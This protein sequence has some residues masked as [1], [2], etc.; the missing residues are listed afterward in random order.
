[1]SQLRL[2]PLTGRWVTVVSER[3]ERPTDFAPRD[4]RIET[5]DRPCPF[6]PGHEE[7]TPPALETYGRDGR[8]QIRVVPNLFPA[9]DGDEPMAVSHLGPVFTQ[10][11][12]S[13]IH[14]ILVLSPEHGESW[15]DLEDRDVGLLMAALRD[16][17]EDH[18]R[19]P[20]IRYT[21]AV[22]NYGREAGA[23]LSHP[24]GQ[25]LGMPFVPGE[26]LEEE[27]GFARFEGSCLICTTIE[28]ELSDN[29][30]VVAEDERVVAVCPFWSG[31]P[32]EILI[33]PKSHVSHLQA[34]SPADLVAVGR[35]IRGVLN[36][37]R[38]H[39]GDVAY[40]LVFHT[41]PHRHDGL[42]HWHVHIWPKLSTLAGFERGTGVL[43]NITP[44]EEAAQALKR[45]AGALT[46]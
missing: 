12:A 23:S 33:M 14:E 46:V 1:M 32:Y 3:G 44:P 42:F 2:N 8:W 21:Q 13:G 17:M 19:S 9:F 24:H 22:V 40:N 34:A 27:A 25:L 41:A 39:L 29:L 43:I 6:C 11:T 31:T 26:I 7:S 10:A 28:A 30:R 16:R 36:T 20:R 37:L 15:A 38:D 4:E 45:T 35:S 18:A 5:V